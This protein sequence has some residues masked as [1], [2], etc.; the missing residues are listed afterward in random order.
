MPQSDLIAAQL[1]CVC[2]KKPPP[3]SGTQITGGLIHIHYYI[4]YIRVE[5]SDRNIHG[6]GIL[7]NHPAVGRIISGIHHEK[8]QPEFHLPMP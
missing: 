2:I 8:M 6:F 4:E 5:Y 3:H 7:F 1:L